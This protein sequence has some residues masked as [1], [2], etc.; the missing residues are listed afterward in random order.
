MTL[1][2]NIDLKIIS[3]NLNNLLENNTI[4]QNIQSKNTKIWKI[5]YLNENDL[6]N[7]E[8]IIDIINESAFCNYCIKELNDWRLVKDYLEFYYCSVIDSSTL[9][10]DLDVE[11]NVIKYKNLSILPKILLDKYSFDNKFKYIVDIFFVKDSC[12]IFKFIINDL[13]ENVQTYEEDH[14]YLPY[15]LQFDLIN[16][17]FEY[18]NREFNSIRGI[19][20]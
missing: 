7:N 13:N 6:I 10:L 16:N 5:T 18:K 20:C 9:F 2:K 1:F 17:Y 14:L 11:L 8:R 12:D 19:I 4:L 15:K 3:F